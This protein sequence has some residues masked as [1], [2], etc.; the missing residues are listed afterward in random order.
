MSR[1]ISHLPALLLHGSPGAPI[2]SPRSAARPP[3][4]WRATSA[5]NERDRLL[6]SAEKYRVILNTRRSGVNVESRFEL[7]QA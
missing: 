6:R 5:A 4:S 1:A 3:S 2:G 7:Q